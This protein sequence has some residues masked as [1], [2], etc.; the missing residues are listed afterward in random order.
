MVLDP[1][2]SSLRGRFKANWLRLV[3]AVAQFLGVG[4]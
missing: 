1:D 3:V 4:L 2:K